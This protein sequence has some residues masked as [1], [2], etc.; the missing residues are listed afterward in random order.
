MSETELRVV[1]KSCGAEVS[2]YVTECPYCGSRVRKRAPQLERR[3]GGLEASRT[4]KELR[5]ER[6]KKRKQKRQAKI[7]GRPLVTW[8]LILIPAIA[9]LARIASGGDLVAFGA[10][11]V[12]FE[13]GPWRFLTAQF[14]YLSV[15]YLFAVALA[16]AIFAPGL[17][18]RLG[19]AATAVLLIACG[20]LGTM[21]AWAIEEQTGTI[22]AIAGGNGM[23]LG[24]IA[25]W[26]VISRP[27]AERRGEDVDSIGVL[28]AATVILLLPVV[29]VTADFWSGL[30]GGAI[31]ALS[32]VIAARYLARR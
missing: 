22:G 20:A 31:G 25:A 26:F 24:A 12:P 28:V 23:A 11:S 9:L 5:Q 29:V 32:G 16:L 10:V 7:A 3:D 30:T 27:E 1:C 19:P 8:A 6:R 2:P 18:R 15:G 14:A 17:E 13:S 4:K 21:G